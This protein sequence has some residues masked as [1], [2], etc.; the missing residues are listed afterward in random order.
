[1]GGEGGTG[2]EMEHPLERQKALRAAKGKGRPLG[3]PALRLPGTAA[4]TCPPPCT[5]R[6]S[7]SFLL[8]SSLELSDTKVDEP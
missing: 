2:E 1:M 8:L 6:N 5:F 3:V 4:G 7:S